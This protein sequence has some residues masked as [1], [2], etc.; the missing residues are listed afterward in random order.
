MAGII[1]VEEI[2]RLQDRMSRLMGDLGLQD[3]ESRYMDEMQRIQERMNRLME[4]GGQAGAKAGGAPG[5]VVMP[6]ADVRETDDSVIVTMDLPGV[7]KSDVDI[8]VTDND[9]TVRAAKAS[10]METEQEGYHKKERTF[11]RFERTVALPVEV[12]SDQ[13]RARL[14]NGVLEITLPKEVVTSRKRI[15]ID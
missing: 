11:V 3:I 14:N 6:L 10:S 9:L 12:K 2:K 4:T 8:T 15:S 5:E 13:A 7:D 1:P